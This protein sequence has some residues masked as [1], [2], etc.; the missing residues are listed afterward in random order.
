MKKRTGP[1]CRLRNFG[2]VTSQA[3]VAKYLSECRS[4]LSCARSLMVI[5]TGGA[6]DYVSLDSLWRCGSGMTLP[7][8]TQCTLPALC[9]SSETQSEIRRLCRQVAGGL[10][11]NVCG[12]RPG[13]SRFTMHLWDAIRYRWQMCTIVIV[14]Y[15]QY[16]TQDMGRWAVR[17]LFYGGLE[18]ASGLSPLRRACTPPPHAASIPFTI[19]L[20]EASAPL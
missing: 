9:S 5:E 16:K 12:A 18:G 8:S 7:H 2:S 17:L 4:P 19:P 6:R 1:A 14:L 3:T 11:G 20:T 13:F 10:I 15:L